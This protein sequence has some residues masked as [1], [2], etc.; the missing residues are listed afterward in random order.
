MTLVL[1]Q[2][3]QIECRSVGHNIVDTVLDKGTPLSDT[4]LDELFDP[5]LDKMQGK[6][7]EAVNASL[8]EFR[9][10]LEDR[11]KSDDLDD[12]ISERRAKITEHIFMSLRCQGRPNY[13][14]RI[15]AFHDIKR[16]TENI[17]VKT[18][19]IGA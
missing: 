3:L 7:I 2:E 16:C 8:D 12:I 19:R 17:S 1:R 5:L 14:G 13:D 18:L 9:G 4:E 10:E 15:Y 6:T 11:H